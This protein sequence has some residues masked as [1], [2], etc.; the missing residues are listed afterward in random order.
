MPDNSEKPWG[1]RH[2]PPVPDE[3]H[4]VVSDEVEPSDQNNECGSLLA[5]VRLIIAQ[6]PD[7]KRLSKAVVDEPNL[8]FLLYNKYAE[9]RKAFEHAVSKLE[10]WLKQGL[11]EGDGF[12]EDTGTRS[13]ITLREWQSRVIKIWENRLINP[14]RGTRTTYPWISDVEINLKNVAEILQEPIADVTEPAEVTPVAISKNDGEA[15]D[16][17][18]RRGRTPVVD[19]DRLEAAIEA[20]C[21]EIGYP[22]GKEGIRGWRF[23]TDVLNWAQKDICANEN[24]TVSKK[25]IAPH[26]RKILIKLKPKY[27]ETQK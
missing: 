19:W 3:T 17:A 25:T 16:L 11:V 8:A 24:V 10:E 23:Q 21:D 13:L 20:H 26:V 27:E 22:E 18:R 7:G 6:G 5:A 2:P 1:G 15:K 4:G 9:V 12:H 14:L